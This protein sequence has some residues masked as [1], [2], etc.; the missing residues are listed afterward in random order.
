MPDRTI[1]KPS[2]D[3]PITVEP[4]GK[5]VN[6]SVAGHA[7][8]DTDRAL[9][10]KEADY[11]VV[12]YIPL[13]DV[14]QKLLERTDHATYCPYKGDAS[15]F[16][17]PAAGD[18]GENAVWQYQEPYGPVAE[19]RDYVAFYDGRVQITASESPTN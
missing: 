9:E 16:S 19:I 5:H 17:I 1:L 12:F 11:P 7:V 3:H 15:Y 8:A 14:D 2:P 13:D 4:S 10:L 6:V 18:A